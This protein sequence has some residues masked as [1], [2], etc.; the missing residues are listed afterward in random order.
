MEKGYFHR[1]AA[2][3]PT[4]FW[5][6]NVTREE[7]RLAIEAGAT[8]CTQNPSYVWKMLS[9]PIEGTHSESLLEE[10]LALGLDDRT[11]LLQG[12][13]AL[14]AQIAQLFKPLYDSSN[15]KQ[16]YVSIQ[17]DPFSEDMESIV[18]QARFNREAGA[19]IMAKIPVTIQGLKAIHILVKEEVPI[20]AT[21]VMS[22]RQAMDVCQVVKEAVHGMKHPPVVYLSHIAGIF[23]E[24]IRLAVKRDGLSVPDDYV[25]QAG[26]AVA[27][28]IHRMVRETGVEIG[29]ISGGARGLQHV[30]ETIGLKGAFTINWQG[31]AE[32][33]LKT[34]PPVVQRFLQPTPYAVTE[35]LCSRIPDFDKAYR[36]GAIMP[37]EYET[38]GPV[39]LFRESFEEAWQKALDWIAQARIKQ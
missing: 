4:A 13:R 22:L 37:E 3:T 8:G 20:N 39:A 35:T 7:A 21:E 9:H 15:Q 10:L 17:G 34:N 29:F 28:K 14:V 38:F 19:N 6:N 12:Q 33:M 32:E 27:K 31:F 25:W 11:V 5:I 2:Q 24:Y 30:T 18:S 16:G 36:Y 26:M 1:V 23:D